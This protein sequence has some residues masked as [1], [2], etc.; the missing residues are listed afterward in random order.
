MIQ[1]VDFH[2]VL[3]LSVVLYIPMVERVYLVGH[4]VLVPYQLADHT[5]TKIDMDIK[6]TWKTLKTRL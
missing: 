1:Q 6:S 5:K 2:L 4:C 3:F